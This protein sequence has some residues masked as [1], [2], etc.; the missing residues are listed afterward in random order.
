[1]V[2]ATAQPPASCPTV[3]S[4]KAF[5]GLGDDADYALAPGGDFEPGAPSWTLRGGATAA[6]GN[7][8]LGVRAGSR[9]LRLPPQAVAISPP[10]CVDPSHPTFRFAARIDSPLSGYVAAVLYRDAAQTL[11]QSRFNASSTQRLLPSG[12]WFASDK[13]PLGV[14]IPLLASAPTAS[15]QL[16]FISTPTL[17]A[18]SALT[19]GLTGTVS[20]DSVMIDPYRRG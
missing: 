5:A 12:A 15:A 18:V 19:L 6:A 11:R 2:A 10:F 1:M 16:M 8:S 17:G 4:T 13:A 9:S 14:N 3:A 7:E 20:I